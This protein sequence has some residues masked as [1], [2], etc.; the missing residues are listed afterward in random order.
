MSSFLWRGWS[1]DTTCNEY[2]KL[3]R[4]ADE[5]LASLN[6]ATSP[7]QFAEAQKS[8]L[9]LWQELQALMD[10]LHPHFPG[11]HRCL[12]HC[13]LEFAI[14]IRNKALLIQPEQPQTPAAPAPSPQPLSDEELMERLK[15][16]VKESTKETFFGQ[17]QE[18][19]GEEEESQ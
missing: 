17:D 18:K 2:A 4:V 13:Y 19:E 5:L 16:Y 10:P 9:F 3:Q 12:K 15:E 1:P 8:L 7:E 14:R 6:G 11:G